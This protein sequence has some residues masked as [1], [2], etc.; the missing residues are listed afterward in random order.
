MT[1]YRKF[2]LRVD[3]V[4]N[5]ILN[6]SDDES[7]NGAIFSVKK[8][9]CGSF[10]VKVRCWSDKG[11]DKAYTFKKDQDAFNLMTLWMIHRTPMKNIHRSSLLNIAKEYWKEKGHEEQQRRLKTLEDVV[12]TQL[13]PRLDYERMQEELDAAV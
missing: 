8:Q 9:Q 3:K 6:D 11:S 7:A 4:V 5:H 12:W 2:M 13:K 10:C 1:G